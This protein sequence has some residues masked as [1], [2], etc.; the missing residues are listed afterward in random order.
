MEAVEKKRP[1]QLS[2]CGAGE[3]CQTVF[4]VPQ[5]SVT[6]S[7][8]PQVYGKDEKIEFHV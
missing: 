8:L 1:F 5:I 6:V 7:F 2:V 3:G 4:H